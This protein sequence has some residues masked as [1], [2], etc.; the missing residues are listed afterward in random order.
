MKLNSERDRS[1]ERDNFMPVWAIF[2]PGLMLASVINN[3]MVEIVLV[4]V[5]VIIMHSSY[6]TYLRKYPT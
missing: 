1:S 3:I 5:E 2:R 6:N 4:L